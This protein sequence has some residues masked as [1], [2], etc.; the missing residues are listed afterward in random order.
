[1][2]A[3]KCGYGLGGVYIH[4]P[5]CPVMDPRYPAEKARGYAAYDAA[6]AAGDVM[7]SDRDGFA[8]AFAQIATALPERRSDTP[9][10][11]VAV[12]KPRRLAPVH[13]CTITAQVD[14]IHSIAKGV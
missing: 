14:R 10:R 7:P 9:C 1:M 3:C 6:R 5:D 8:R 12:P 13:P 11:D 4:M 2:P